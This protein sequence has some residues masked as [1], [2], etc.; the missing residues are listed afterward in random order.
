MKLPSLYA[1]LD[2]KLAPCPIETAEAMLAG[3]VKLLQY[4]HKGEFARK[5]WE[6]CL[7][8]SLLGC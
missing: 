1:I 8:L 6:Q 2:T 5:H 3:G 4:R 7:V